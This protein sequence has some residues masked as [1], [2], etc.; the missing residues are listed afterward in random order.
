MYHWYDGGTRRKGNPD[1][2]S[3]SRRLPTLIHLLTVDKKDYPISFFLKCIIFYRAQDSRYIDLF[4]APSQ[5]RGTL[6]F[7]LRVPAKFL[8]CSIT[9]IP[10]P[11]LL[12]FP[13][14]HHCSSGY[15]VCK[16]HRYVHF[17]LKV[18]LAIFSLSSMQVLNQVPSEC[19][20]FP[21]S[22]LA[23]KNK[24]LSKLKMI[25]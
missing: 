13:V 1:R 25:F 18:D 3:L 9:P 24:N 21:F 4:L 14:I 19:R 6:S 22:W 23:Q 8:M 20:I 15:R 16:E 11:I 17:Y 5:S 2:F 7:T 10:L 12:K